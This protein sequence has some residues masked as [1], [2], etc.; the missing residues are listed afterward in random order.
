MIRSISMLK[1][2]I[3]PEIQLLIEQKNWRTLKDALSVW[4]APD[5]A[6]LLEGLE[7]KDSIILFLLLHRE[8]KGDVFGDLEPEKQENLLQQL[9][10]EQVREVILELPPDDRTELFE[11]LTENKQGGAAESLMIA[12]LFVVYGNE[13]VNLSNVLDKKDEAG[14]AR[15]HVDEMIAAIKKEG[16]DGQWFLRAYDYFGE[17]IGSKE[18]EEGKIFIES[19]GFCIMAGVGLDDGKAQKALDSV[20]KYLDCEYGIVLL[21]PAFTKYYLNMGEISTYPPGYKENAGIFCHNNP[22]I[23]IGE[24]LV[25][26]GNRAFEYYSKIAPSYLEEIS[27]LHKTE[28][29]TY[30]QMIAGKDAYK[31][32]EAK[33]SWL[34]GT[35]AWNYYA[36][37]QYILG[38]QPQYNGLKVDPCIPKEWDGFEISRKFRGLNFKIEIK[39]PK[40]IAKGIE[41]LIV[42]GK[43]IEG[44]II[45]I[46][47]TKTENI[48][49]VIM[50]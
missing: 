17:K 28:P 15:K 19:Q 32:G 1:E 38:I 43:E 10:N 36:I 48:V 29:Y 22:W 16:W 25:G 34:T 31:P 46:D 26:N 6:D 27:D 21:N 40:H 45:P 5:I 20:K 13:F 23:M 33:N 24:T 12:G 14:E 18:N 4:P 47:K 41:K 7:D 50:G 30:A 3:K 37:T 39:N 44:N 11:E 42:N 8:M 35:A 2:P 9:N 49:E